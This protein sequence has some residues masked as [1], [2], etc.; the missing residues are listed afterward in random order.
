MY[1]L[2]YIKLFMALCIFLVV[3]K[4]YY[5]SKAYLG[6]KGILYYKRKISLIRKKKMREVEHERECR[7]F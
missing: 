2:T 7:N 3:L 4:I 1:L 6:F 5:F